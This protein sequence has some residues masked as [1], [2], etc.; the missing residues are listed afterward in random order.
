MSRVDGG[1]LASRLR[2]R[3]DELGVSLSQVAAACNVSKSL[4][5]QWA[6]G[7]ARPGETALDALAAYLSLEP[8]WLLTGEGPKARVERL[9]LADARLVA[10]RRRLRDLSTEAKGVRSEIRH[11]EGEQADAHERAFARARGV[12]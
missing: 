10:L 4:A 3:L 11:L 8:A 2:S 12:A 1:T 5:G 9:T 6:K 7:D